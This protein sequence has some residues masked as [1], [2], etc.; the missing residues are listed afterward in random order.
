MSQRLL[1]QSIS[2]TIR[3]AIGRGSKSMRKW[4]RWKSVAILNFTMQETLNN[5][6]PLVES[7]QSSLTLLRLSLHLPS[8]STLTL[9][10]PYQ[11]SKTTTHTLKVATSTYSKTVQCKTRSWTKT[12][13]ILICAYEIFVK[14]SKR[15]YQSLSSWIRRRSSMLSCSRKGPQTRRSPTSALKESRALGANYE[16]HSTTDLR[17]SQNYSMTRWSAQGSSR[18]LSGSLCHK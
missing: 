7:L 13:W 14:W 9:E 5:L 8:H 12:R 18:R 1:Q 4:R 17:Q 3:L 11:G 15:S 6:Q 10:I 2:L 16:A